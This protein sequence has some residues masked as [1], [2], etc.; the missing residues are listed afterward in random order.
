MRVLCEKCDQKYTIDEDK[1]KTEVSRFKCKKCSHYITVTK[2]RSEF[3]EVG[4]GLLLKKSDRV[5]SMLQEVSNQPEIGDESSGP[6]YGSDF[7]FNSS[8]NG[9][10]ASTGAGQGES[11]PK[12]D[13][14]SKKNDKAL[15]MRAFM[16][17]TFLVGFLLMAGAMV[18]LYWQYVPSLVNE[19]IDLRTAAISRS[20]SGAVKQ[21]LIVR[22]YLRVNQ[23]AERISQLPGVAYASVINKRDIVI[24]GVF[25]KPSLFDSVFL[26]MVT[27]SGFP[28]ELS[29]KNNLNGNETEKGREFVMGGQP[30]YDVATSLEGVGGEVHVGLFMANTQESIKKSFMPLLVSISVLFVLG[31]IAFSLLARFIS[32]PLQDLTEMAN[33]ISQGEVDEQIVPK[34]PRE[35]RILARS[36]DRMR[37]SIRGALKRLKA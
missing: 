32:Q 26:E 35:I 12:A 11:A 18:L 37:I 22:N 1:L 3:D 8:A 7:N 31:M 6:G 28:K 17:M 24:A 25:A 14:D 23:E 16:S 13:A 29:N 5:Y 19:Q 30:I 2:S 21:P 4:N 9:D 10:S 34:G 20:F 36:L 33:R 27:N 15:T